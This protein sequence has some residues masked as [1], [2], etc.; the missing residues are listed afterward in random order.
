M[1]SANVR[2]AIVRAAIASEVDRYQHSEVHDV[3]DGERAEAHCTLYSG[4]G[5]RVCGVT[6][7]RTD[8][9]AEIT[10]DGYDRKAP[11]LNALE[12][13]LGRG[14]EFVRDSDHLAPFLSACVVKV[15][16]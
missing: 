9:G 13:F 4:D 5:S 6:A 16:R 11:A 3:V 8:D 7:K 10:L 2:S 14:V 12:S 15:T 1:T